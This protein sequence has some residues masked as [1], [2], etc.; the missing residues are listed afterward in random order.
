[1]KKPNIQPNDVHVIIN[2]WESPTRYVGE[3]TCYNAAGK[4]LWSIPALCKGVEGP[5]HTIRGGDTPP[6]LYLAG[7]VVVT[8]PGDSAQTWNAYGKYFID[9]VE[10]ENQEAGLGRAG[11]G[12]HGGGTAAADPLAPQ[13]TLL[14]T[15][16]CVR[17]HNEHI[18]KFVVATLQRVNQKGGRMWITVNQFS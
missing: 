11:I 2:D 7:D 5:R 12:W 10:Q 15:L 4:R 17:S 13:Q 9:M 14:P 1:M 8:Q 6:G 3:A 16:G 18:A